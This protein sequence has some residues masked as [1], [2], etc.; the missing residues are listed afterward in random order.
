MENKIIFRAGMKKH[1]GSLFG[2]AILMFLTVLS[3][4]TVLTVFISGGQYVKQEMQRVGFGNLTA[5]VSLV[6]D[7][8]ALTESI[9]RQDG[10][11][12]T[13]VQRLIF[14]EYESNGV[15][16][17]SEGQLIPWVLGENKY[18]F[19]QDDLSGF[20]EQPQEIKT[21]EVYVSPSMISVLNL[22]IGDVITFPVA[23]GG[24]AINL[25]V[26]GYYEDPFMGSSMIGMKGFLISETDYN[27]MQKT[28]REA[29][30]NSLARDGAMVHLYTNGDS[31]ISDVNLLL[32]E[33][34]PLSQYTEFLHSA[35]AIAGFMV[36]LQNAF[37]GLLAAFALVLL[38]AVLVILGHSITG[39]IQQEY[40]NLGILKTVGLTGNRLI[41]LQL[42]QYLTAILVGMLPGILAAIPLA[43]F[44]ARITLT[45]TG[46]LFPARLPLLPCLVVFS[47][48]LLLLVGFTVWK[49][50]IISTV[51]PMKA[52]RGDIE[53]SSWEPGKNSKIGIK[54]L[55]FH[56]AIRQLRSGKK[57][58]LSVCMIAI[59]LVFFASLAGRMNSWLG[60]DGKGMMDA[61]NPADLD[62]GVQILG[63]LNPE[64]MEQMVRSF[65]D[66]TDSYL[67]A[68]PSVSVNG[69]NYTANV[70]TEPERFHI[71]QGETS[72]GDDE[73]VLTE[74][75]SQDLGAAVKDKVTVRGDAGSREFTVSGIYHCANDMGANIGMSRE[76]YLSIGQDSKNLWC[77]HYFLEDVSQRD[78][79]TEALQAAYGGDVHVHENTWPGLR[80]IIAAM[81]G[82][83]AVMYGMIALFIF[84]VTVMTGSRILSAEQKDLGIYKS[85]GYSAGI[86]RMTFSLRFGIV[87]VIGA[88][89]GTIFARLLT[90]SL[91]SLVMRFAGIS[92]F[93]SHPSAINILMPGLTV[94]LMFLLFPFFVSGRIKKADMTVLTAAP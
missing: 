66:I 51:S 55:S 93:A 76:G 86:L 10:I 31:S 29:G 56:L 64:E 70:I 3:L 74:A 37:S 24:S 83:L 2:I 8:G 58:Y 81:Q 91:V 72:M 52:I 80:G 23:R 77:H 50:K 28:I 25:T 40:K 59:L 12:R 14:S 26:A 84:I 35:D 92:N 79:I 88:A 53:Q 5:W 54:G 41:R 75:A 45:T 61:F 44:I 38:I 34:T 19:F 42:L 85:M 43:S 65:T 90:D 39:I 9:Q 4:S 89:L 71:S 94:I 78:A 1:K 87:A 73:I 13:E 17:D 7:M 62:M 15:E 11:E 67:L 32:N 57:R 68:M 36:I 30:M 33:N 22:K 6:P 60:E 82:L 69:S 47:S 21:G 20:Q 27:A 16:S 48:I 46:I 49:L 18:H 63:E